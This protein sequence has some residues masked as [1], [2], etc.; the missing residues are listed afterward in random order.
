MTPRARW[1]ILGFSLLGLAFAS[2]SIWVHYRL[3]TDPSYISPCASSATVNCTQAYLSR[4]GS[5]FGVPVAI[6]GVAW[7]ALVALI[8]AFAK[9]DRPGT[10]ATSSAGGYIFALA[11]V[12]LAAILYLAYASWFVIHTYCLLCIGSYVSVLGIFIVSGL[13]A[14]VSVAQ[15]PVRAAQDL[16]A[17]FRKPL[18][19]IAALVYIALTAS[20]V[21][22]FP[23]E[24]RAPT[25][26]PPPPPV[27][28]QEQFAKAWDAQPRV[29][30]GISPGT[31]KVVVVKFNDW[32]CPM[33]KAMA[34]A[35]QPVLDKYAKSD[36]GAVKV[37][38][39]DWPW[40]TDC[41]SSAGRTIPG[42]E[43]ACDAVVAVRLAR[44]HGK[45]DEMIDWLFE[46]QQQLTELGASGAGAKASEMIRQK[47]GEMLGVKDFN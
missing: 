29:D 37:I 22:L 4:F 33:C 18:T 45:A 17:V 46:N 27:S 2:E 34:L 44:D 5:I 35:Y 20:C 32:L 23:R 31:A 24:M 36:P 30:L 10:P 9:P 12:G 38:I 21:V 39:K 16:G 6:G 8:A 26:P 40:N 1:L 14:S 13:S 41:N 43:G 15:L 47:A 11:T 3:L 28:Q 42:H 7:F 19:L 25:A